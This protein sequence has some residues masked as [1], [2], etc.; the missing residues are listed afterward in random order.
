[1]TS[2]RH[3]SCQV[4]KQPPNADTCS[5]KHT[6]TY[7]QMSHKHAYTHSQRHAHSVYGNVLIARELPAVWD[8]W[9]NRAPPVPLIFPS[10]AK[11]D[12]LSNW[13]HLLLL[14]HPTLNGS[15]SAIFSSSVYPCLCCSFLSVLLHVWSQSTRYCA[16]TL[17]HI[18]AVWGGDERVI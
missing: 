9:E 12:S 7:K 5:Y 4:F 10:Q 11:R 18:K 16:I 17:N 1:M 15:L 13:S 14:P 2:A 3:L 6:R 8:L